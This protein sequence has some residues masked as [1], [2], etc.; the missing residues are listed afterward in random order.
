[1]NSLYYGDGEM[2]MKYAINRVALSDDLYTDNMNFGF[3]YDLGKFM[4][5]I[6]GI[7]GMA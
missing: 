6:N 5:N 7:M 4:N 3:G 2:Q 1:M